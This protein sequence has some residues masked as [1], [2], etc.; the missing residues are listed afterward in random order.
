MQ[1]SAS[2]H[3]YIY[4][5]VHRDGMLAAFKFSPTILACDFITFQGSKLYVSLE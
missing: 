3:V 2:Q 1:I 4:F 5:P